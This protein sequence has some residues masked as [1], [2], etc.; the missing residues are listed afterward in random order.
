MFGDIIGCV[1]CHFSLEAELYTIKDI[2]ISQSANACFH[3]TR[4]WTHQ[5]WHRGMRNEVSLH[6]PNE[7]QSVMKISLRQEELQEQHQGWQS[8]KNNHLLSD[9]G[10]RFH[11]IRFVHHNISHQ[12]GGT[13]LHLHH[14]N[15][16][17]D[18]RYLVW[19]SV[20]TPGRLCDVATLSVCPCTSLD[21]SQ[22][23][24]EMPNKTVA[25]HKCC[26]LPMLVA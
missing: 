7:C 26:M 13:L 1:R 19:Y 17:G 22:I 21:F 2:T 25:L 6:L 23:V 11:A 5:R 8:R 20:L 9:K 10:R 12:S 14:R 24:E 18:C 3:A 4:Y 16:L 15:L